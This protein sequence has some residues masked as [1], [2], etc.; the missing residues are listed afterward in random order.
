MLKLFNKIK[1]EYYIPEFIRLA[2]VATIYKGKGEK[3]ELENDRGIFLV[4]L[5][6]SILMRLIYMDKY[7]II[8]SC[9]SDSQVGGRK[10]KNVRNHIW[11]LNGVITDVLSTKKNT[12][13]DIQIFDYKQC[14]DSLWLNECLNDIYESGVTDDKLALLYD[15][16]THVKVAV[17]TPVGISDRTSI[18]NVITQGDVFGPILCSNQVDTFGR[19]CLEEGKY[20]YTYKGE[21]EIP[22]LGMVD[23]LIC[24]SQCGHKTA[25]MNAFINFKTNSKKLQF[26]AK[27]CKK[28][29]VGHLHEEFKC[30]DLSVEKW[31][32]LEVTND[33]TGE[34]EI[35]DIWSGEEN[36]EEKTEEKYLGDIISKDGKNIKNIKARISKG[37]GI[38]NKILMVLDGIPFGKHYFEVGILL[39]NSLLVSS[40]LFNCEAWYNLSGAELD[41]LETID[42]QLLRQLLQAPKGT[43]K[44]MLFLELGV[45]P[46]REII[47]ERRLGF[48]YYILNEEPKSMINKF[49]Q[50]QMKNRTKRDW[51]TT[52]LD[53]LEK[54]D[55]KELSLETIKTMKKVSFMNIVKRKIN[56]RS[57][58]NLIKVKNSHSKVQ[59]LEYTCLKIQKYLQPNRTEIKR[60]EAQLIFR[61]RCRVTEAKVNLRGKYDNLECG[62]C[63]LE[64]EN[65][66]HIL[67]CKMLNGSK[68]QEELKYINLLTGTVTDKLKLAKRFKENFAILEKIKKEKT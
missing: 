63:G 24:I 61:L 58:E 1:K 66:Q 32:E 15:I 8:D 67:D 21:V 11:V 38:V 4:A 45:K 53:D 47:R 52:I 65:Q 54:L 22:P 59:Q 44:E 25:M 18:Y 35:K 43:P 51:A 57:F 23:D 27:K 2:D 34:A 60:E 9:M 30:Q 5:F 17:K 42:L 36:I 29:H 56:E 28:L 31:T 13:I 40:M 33:I 48:L 26:G 55:M 64:E 3:C 41:L 50:I 10:G 12:P 62:A 46:F 20:T 49:F 16:N 19:E 14:F 7:A 37:K 68:I 6:R 39:R